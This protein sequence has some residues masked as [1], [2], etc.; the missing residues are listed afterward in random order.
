ME[1]EFFCLLPQNEKVRGFSCCA[2]H[3]ILK[4]QTL[5]LAHGSIIFDELTN[6]G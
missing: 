5:C 3:G 6:E 1:K 2:S 4:P